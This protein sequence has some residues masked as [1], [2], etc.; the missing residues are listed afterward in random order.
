MTYEEARLIWPDKTFL[1]NINLSD[2]NLEPQDLRKKIH[3]FIRQAS[4][5][6]LNLWFQISE[7]LPTNWE[8]SIP[9]VLDALSGY[10]I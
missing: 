3:E 10:S 4:P 8:K 1:A 5:D 7:D 2:Y 6:G 9:V